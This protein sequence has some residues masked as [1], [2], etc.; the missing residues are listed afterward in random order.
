MDL[1]I[2]K[3]VGFMNNNYVFQDKNTIKKSFTKCRKD[4]I[5]NFKLNENGSINEWFKVS[6]FHAKPL[7]SNDLTN[8]VFIISN[9]ELVKQ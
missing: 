8:D 3:Y 4:L 9:M 7:T 5:E 2:C 6:Y 1:M